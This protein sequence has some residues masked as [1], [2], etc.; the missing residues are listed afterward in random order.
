MIGTRP[1]TWTLGA[2]TLVAT[3]V[4]AACSSGTPTATPK[5]SGTT[6]ATQ[7]A[8]ATG[9]PAT[10]ATAVSSATP[11][12]GGTTLTMWG[13]N[14]DEKVYTAIK[15]KWNATHPNQIEL[16]II[17]ANEYIA[18]IAAA[19]SGGGLPDL[20]DVDLI[21]MPDFIDQ[22]LF[23]PITDK[24]NA[25]AHKADLSPGHVQVST[26][27][28]GQIY[29]V[30]FYVDASS[31][32]WNKDL[33]AKAGLD[34]EKGPT[35][36]AEVMDHAKKIRAL[37]GDTYGFYFAGNAA[38]PNA[39]TYLPQMWAAGG[40]VIDYTNHK[41]TM[42]SSAQVKEALQY[43]QD[44]Y[45]AGVMPESVK[46]EGGDTWLKT[47]ASGKIGIQP[48]GG[49]WGI[50]GVAE[51]NPSMKFGVTYLPGKTS[52]Q[53]ASFAGGD[54]IAITKS[55]KDLDAAWEFIEWSLSDD[56]QLEIYAKNGAFTSRTDLADNKY[57]QADPRYVLNN[58][59]LKQGQ[60]PRTLGYNEIFNDVNGPWLAAIR[61][62]V[63]DGDV[64]GA[65]AAGD[66]AIQTILDTHYK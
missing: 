43:Y 31:L 6:T 51:Q 23:Q 58:Q 33:Y 1:R 5:P 28:D 17:P 56:V 26:S 21:Y 52:G 30:P 40:D 54:T 36:W 7:P 34:P 8:A 39:Y 15:D 41:A 2:L 22:K 65:V 37:G 53:K 11:A 42:S 12:A 29:G 66:K 60:T 46:A 16:T 20:L 14:V 27:D 13:R 19:A 59:A 32:F 47:F 38:G 49:G 57:S 64:D 4:A 25:Y 24:V 61:K 48:L 62:A 3:M 10:G 55:A 35:S 63:F 45:K 9:T 50:R 44:L 18:R